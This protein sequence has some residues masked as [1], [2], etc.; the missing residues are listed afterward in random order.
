[1]SV[2]TG[3]GSKQKLRLT[4][5]AQDR[6]AQRKITVMLYHS[7]VFIQQLGCRS[8]TV[9]MAMIMARGLGTCGSIS[10]TNSLKPRA[11]LEPVSFELHILTQT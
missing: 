10:T 7:K 1:M 3:T 8:S 4:L 2:A 6:K 5:S 11:L 9:A